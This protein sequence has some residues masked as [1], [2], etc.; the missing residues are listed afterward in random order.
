VLT[1][2]IDAIVFEAWMLLSDVLKILAGSI[3]VILV[4]AALDF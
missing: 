3:L 4:L 1:V 2:V